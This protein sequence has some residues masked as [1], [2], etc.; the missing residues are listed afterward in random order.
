VILKTIESLNNPLQQDFIKACLSQLSSR[1]P[2]ARKLL[3]HPVI[4]EVPSL[5]LLSTHVIVNT[6]SY[7]PE[8]LT[9]EALHRPPDTHTNANNK[10]EKIEVILAEIKPTATRQGITLKAS[11][12]PRREVEKFFEEVRNGA[13]PL[14]ALM[15]TYRPPIISRQR[16]TSP[17]LAESPD[18]FHEEPELRRL[19]TVRCFSKQ[20]SIAGQEAGV[21]QSTNSVSLDRSVTLLLRLDDK[22][23]RQLS[24]ELRPSDTPKGL[25]EEL[26][27]FGLIHADDRELVA[28]AIEETLTGNRNQ[29]VVEIITESVACQSD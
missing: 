26:L 25:V 27:S 4:F 11:E 18:S 7:L 16:T 8:Q 22:M 14:T 1:R 21:G 3:F 20:P 9:E 2:P 17:E 28:K 19:A 23:N 6:P 10:E 24:C 13:H 12:V 5:R 15:P 29:E